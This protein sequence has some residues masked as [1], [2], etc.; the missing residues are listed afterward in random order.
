MRERRDAAGGGGGG[1]WKGGSWEV[2]TNL[3]C[4]CGLPQNACPSHRP[5]GLFYV[6]LLLASC[7]GLFYRSI[8]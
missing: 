4:C 3:R 6:S 1:A 2:V 7:I 5:V 8:L